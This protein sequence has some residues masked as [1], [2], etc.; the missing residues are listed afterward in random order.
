MVAAA[1]AASALTVLVAG[2]LLAAMPLGNDPELAR[3]LGFEPTERQEP[4]G[5]ELRGVPL[6]KGVRVD[7][8]RFRAIA[9]RM[10]ILDG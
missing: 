6:P 4:S 9:V 3:R 5:V 10:A 1:V 7:D 8:D 2:A